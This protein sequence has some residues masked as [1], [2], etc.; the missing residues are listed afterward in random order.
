MSVNLRF[1]KGSTVI[2]TSLRDEAFPELLKLVTDFESQEEVRQAPA[3]SDVL[4]EWSI[5]NDQ[6][7]KS[8]EE[9]SEFAK[10]WLSEHSPAETLA[11][12][13]W[14]TFPERIL[15]LG[16]LIEASGNNVGW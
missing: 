5:S 16:G 6:N 14:E 3:E 15:A 7:K 4:P 11:F 12:F 10:K 2:Q 8:V 9:R 1:Q 13:G